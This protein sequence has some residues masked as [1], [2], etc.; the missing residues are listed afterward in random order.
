MS[1]YSEKTLREV[2]EA[3]DAV[4]VLKLIG[5]RPETVQSSESQIRCFCPIHKEAVFRTMAVALPEKTFACSYALCPGAKGGHLIQ[6]YAL[7]TGMS[8]DAA[9]PKLVETFGLE[10]D[11]PTAEVRLESVL[12]LGQNYLEM[13][14]FDKSETA[15]RQAL[16]ID[17]K[18]LAAHQGL[19][20][21]LEK[22]GKA[23]A[24]RA[25]RFALAELAQEL[26]RLDMSCQ[27]LE[28]HLEN[29][30]ED[31]ETRTRLIELYKTRNLVD[32]QVGQYMA[33]AELREADGQ[34]DEALEMYRSI[35]SIGPG[36]VDVFPHVVRLLQSSGRHG[37]AIEENLRRAES[38][39]ADGRADDALECLA[40]A[41]EIDPERQDIR[42]RAIDS[43]LAGA[44]P[45]EL[46]DRALAWVDG[47]IERDAFNE[48]LEALEKLQQR[49]EYDERILKR[50]LEVLERQGKTAQAEELRVRLVDE[51]LTRAD[52]DSA[53]RRLE[54][55][56]RE[57]PNSIDLLR[58][59]GSLLAQTG[60]QELAR[61]VYSELIEILRKEKDIHRSAQVYE[62]ALEVQ[63]DNLELREE[64]LR[65]LNEL[66]DVEGVKAACVDLAERYFDR[67]ESEKA[68]ERIEAAIRLAPDDCE[69]HLWRARAAERLGR[70]DDV[71]ESR[72]KAAQIQMAA[73][74]FVEA[75]AA[76]EA[77]LKLQPKNLEALDLTATCCVELDERARAVKAL[78]ELTR[79]LEEQERWSRCETA[80]RRLLKIDKA[81]LGA[82]E[83]LGRVLGRLDRVE[84]EVAV[85]HDAASGYLEE[86]TY[87]RAEAICEHI[88]ERR[89]GDV[90]AL[91]KLIRV[92]EAAQ[93]AKRV[94]ELSLRL[95]DV[96]RKR[97]DRQNER[98]IY[99]KIL[100]RAPEDHP[101]RR[102]Y[103]FLLWNQHDTQRLEPEVKGLLESL[104]RLRR[105]DEAG[106]ILDEL[107]RQAD[108]E[109]LFLELSVQLY[110]QSAKPEEWSEAVGALADLYR[111]RG[112]YVDAAD[113][114]ARLVERN[115]DDEA[116]RADLIGLL[117]RADRH[118]DAAAQYVKL[119]HLRVESSSWDDAQAAFQAALDLDPSN[120]EAM[121]ALIRLHFQ[122]DAPEA[123]LSLIKSLAGLYEHDERYDEAVGALRMAFEADRD[124]V[125]IRRKIIE[126]LRAQGAVDQ[127]A[128]EMD[129]LRSI[130]ENQQDWPASLC[131]MREKI[132]LLPEEPAPRQDFIEFLRR[133]GQREDCAREEID[134]AELHL[135]HEQV[136]PALEILERLVEENPE[137]LTARRLRAEVYARQG[138]DKKAL[139]EFLSIS[140]SLQ[141]IDPPP[142]AHPVAVQTKLQI[143]DNYVFDT[144]VV[145]ARNN[146]AHAT[147]M[148]VA[149]APG[150][151]YNPLFLHSDVGLG[152]THLLHAIANYLM[153]D[154]PNLKLLYTS[155][156]EF[157]TELVDAIENN[158]VKQFRARH[159]A[160]DVLLLDDVHFLA[161]QERA[162]EEFFHIF[163]TLYQAQRQIAV[164][165]DRPPKDMAH[166]E[167][168]LVSRFGA[169][170]IVDIQP[171]DVET[172][173]AIIQRETRKIEDLELPET[174]SGQL[175]E[176]LEGS[177]R[178]LL[179][180]FNQ[181]VA[182]A[183]LQ[184]RPIKESV[185]N[186]IIQ[187]VLDNV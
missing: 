34:I 3:L 81:Q 47:Y 159:K 176:R 167:K 6:L 52:P 119:G 76:L 87:S 178:E 42:G 152:K 21:S 86:S 60:H 79:F 163:N 49:T 170:V 145:G 63:P 17:P 35:E 150:K 144:F 54:D 156:E 33:L 110:E 40:Q 26:D 166:L 70:A 99:E 27:T 151:A 55:L 162:Q 173:T 180:S 149:K 175:A 122:K 127:A 140:S 133:E 115:P 32:E 93:R 88:L 187:R 91:E 56:L 94:H 165:S 90:V 4:K 77:L 103:I 131:L 24:A 114:T 15:F 125:E 43:A 100:E 124:A 82:L 186:D 9:V 181:I 161:G 155:A 41:L 158:A 25:Q 105:F 57:H 169:G 39:E 101:T 139:A 129:N 85:L 121:K 38:L 67:N 68:L 29:S 66:D 19:L 142:A 123:A 117:T 2:L 108:D 141:D 71:A 128:A 18:N 135:R 126:I 83:R 16:E 62:E 13:G 46:L 36:V 14:I 154:K 73:G 107:R 92:N 84:E 109:P 64:R 48:A 183:R 136:D 160:T 171:P 106:E 118:S 72:L 75:N 1:I 20:A 97:E 10:I 8:E 111:G 96:Y 177:V 98:R 112:R 157:A 12:H 7:S 132:S 61:R 37:Q 51:E 74:A 102:R 172:R 58:R 53:L 174:L 168:R 147:A 78:G 22:A 89:P 80:L 130:Y 134:L 148:A 184:D 146:F 143:M 59:K 182:L 185:L 164:T 44:L 95:A 179:G 113:W 31:I 153:V 5:H 23:D 120:E 11:L 116:M 138:D 50:T 28:A 65:I 45:G 69:L 137:M 30:P 104:L